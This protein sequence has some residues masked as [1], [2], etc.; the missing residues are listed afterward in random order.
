MQR[1]TKQFLS[2]TA[3]L[4][5][6]LARRLALVSHRALLWVLAALLIGGAAVSIFMVDV[7]LPLSQSQLRP[8]GEPAPLGLALLAF[9]LR[10]APLL[11]PAAQLWRRRQG[12]AQNTKT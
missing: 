10:V 8:S 6:L 7:N 5:F 2:G 12:G 9:L 4:A 1:R 3:A 11:L